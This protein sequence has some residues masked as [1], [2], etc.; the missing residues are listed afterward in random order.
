MKHADA[1]LVNTTGC[2]QLIDLKMHYNRIKMMRNYIV[3]TMSYKT[4]TASMN[5]VSIPR[6]AVCAKDTSQCCHKV[7]GGA[8]RGI[9]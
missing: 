6:V 9:P 5:S 7:L 2:F 3:S 4:K 1:I 8:S